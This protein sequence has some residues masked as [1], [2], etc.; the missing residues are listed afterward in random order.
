MNPAGHDGRVDPDRLQSLFVAA[1]EL[2]RE[3]QKLYLAGACGEDG[4]LRRE[5]DDLLAHDLEATTFLQEPLLPRLRGPTLAPG[6]V[7]GG[8]RIE[9]FL[10]PGGSATVYVASDERGASDVAL[11]VVAPTGPGSGARE[12]LLRGVEAAGCVS[13]PSLVQVLRGGEDKAHGAWFCAMRRVRG[14]RLDDALGALTEPGAPLQ[15]PIRSRVVARLINIAEGLAA[16]HGAGL[17]HRDV[18]PANIVL[19]AEAGSD[20]LSG[21]AVLVD[22]GLLAAPR[23]PNEDSALWATFGYASPEQVLGQH[24][25]PASDVFGLGVTAFDLLSGRRPGRRGRATAGPL[26]PLRALVPGLDRALSAVV[27]MATDP[28]PDWRY[29]DAAAMAR[30]LRAALAG[31]RVEALRV[32]HLVRWS[33]RF[34]RA[35]RATLRRIAQFVTAGAAGATAVLGVQHAGALLR[36]VHA[37]DVA[38]RGGDLRGM[39]DAL[40]APPALTAAFLPSDLTRFTMPPERDDPLREVLTVGQRDGWDAALTLAARFLERDGLA[41]QPDLARFL[42]HGMRTPTGGHACSLAARLFFERPDGSEADTAASAPLRAA[43]HALLRAGPDAGVG[44][45]VAVAL[46]GCGDASSVGALA[47]FAARCTSADD[48]ARTECQR[49]ALHAIAMILARTSARRGGARQVPAEAIADLSALAR[50]A[51]ASVGGPLT[52]SP[53]MARAV[54]ELEIELALGGVAPPPDSPRAF[55]PKHVLHVAAARRDPALRARIVGG[56][57]PLP[58]LPGDPRG[59]AWARAADLGFAAGLFDDP[60]CTAALRSLA[61]GFPGAAPALLDDR[62]AT[63]VRRASDLRRGV[64]PAAAPDEESHLATGLL[65]PADLAPCATVVGDPGTRIPPWFA[66]VDLCH[67]T[68][69]VMHAGDRLWQRAADTLADELEEGATFVR[70]ARPGLSAIAFEAL[71]PDGIG[72]CSLWIW[73]QQGVRAALPYDGYAAIDVLL[74]GRPVESGF[75]LRGANGGTLEL[76]LSQVTHARRRRVEVRLAAESTTTVRVYELGLVGR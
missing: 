16:L 59:V 35:R 64:D 41:A 69:I 75:R 33:R 76:P 60:A 44:A 29:P 37:A 61:L 26:P 24:V 68:A 9:G 73:V 17:V 43:L 23:A 63:G 30:D 6:D 66:G 40:A 3:E 58:L 52:V 36:T 50:A 1:R 10:A 4:A 39:A 38:W 20:P 18:K 56:E 51:S 27:A 42:L 49:V 32:P 13:H 54:A 62:F 31:G 15:E 53:R 67:G 5:V 45:N 21:R 11:K 65:V 14:P 19:D 8:Y 25:G 48:D 2:T 71:V 70:L 7:V 72:T 57:D 74:D 47:G 34:V 46:G 22:F 55:E 12:L 28:E